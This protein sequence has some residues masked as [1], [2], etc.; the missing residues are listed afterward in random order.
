MDNSK[1]KK[2]LIIFGITAASG[3]LLAILLALFFGGFAL[4][5]VKVSNGLFLV[6]LVMCMVGAVKGLLPFFRLKKKLRT[7]QVDA[8]VRLEEAP[9][10]KWEYP[11]IA[12]GLVL[13]LLSFLLAV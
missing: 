5:T 12:A 9:K 10:L 7:M 2:L 8:E 6:A 1:T 11:V 3:M 13:V 4:N